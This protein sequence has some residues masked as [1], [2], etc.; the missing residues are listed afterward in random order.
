LEEAFCN[1]RLAQDR[2][3]GYIKG[4]AVAAGGTFSGRAPAFKIPVHLNFKQ[5]DAHASRGF[6]RSG[7]I[8]NSRQH[9][10]GSPLLG[11]FLLFVRLS[12]A[13]SIQTSHLT[14]QPVDDRNVLSQE[15]DSAFCQLVKPARLDLGDPAFFWM[16]R[17][18]RTI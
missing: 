7:L 16:S 11:L 3:A 18:K 1:R 12:L 2:F 15:K 17:D 9:V 10:A 5:N 6:F 8:R 14:S 13:S 4:A